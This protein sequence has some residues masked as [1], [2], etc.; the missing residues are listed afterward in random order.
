[1]SQ[2][3]PQWPPRQPGGPDS[4]PQPWRPGPPPPPY[5]S[6]YDQAQQANGLAVA[7]FVLGI[8][9][10]VFSW[11]GL[12]TLLQVVLALT[13]SA[14]GISRAR[15]G[16]PHKGLAIAGLVLGLVGLVVY[17]LLG[18]ASLGLGWFI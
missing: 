9:S 6:P 1:M 8:T 10:V 11:W 3:T 4:T 18:L 16:A 13:F 14:V 12:L 2:N 17:F 15:R 5:S 7:G